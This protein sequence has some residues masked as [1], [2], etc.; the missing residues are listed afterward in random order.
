MGLLAPRS[1]AGVD[2][3]RGTLGVD[4]AGRARSR[5]RTRGAL[6]E[7]L[8]AG[9][10]ADARAVGPVQVAA[11]R[12]TATPARGLQTISRPAPGQ[13]PGAARALARDD[14]GGARTDARALG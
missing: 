3:R 2:P 5:P 1:A 4:V 9:T 12:R 10:R 14:A 7:P 11:A 8:T 6:E 13:A